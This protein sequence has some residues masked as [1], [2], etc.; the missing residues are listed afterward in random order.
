MNKE[1]AEKFQNTTNYTSWAIQ[2]QLIDICSKKVNEIIFKEIKECGF[3]SVM[4]DEA[5]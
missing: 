1:F 3:F 4:C 2:N 5:R